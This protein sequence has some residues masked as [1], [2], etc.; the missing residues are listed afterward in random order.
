MVEAT[1]RW[2]ATVGESS[3]PGKGP[4]EWQVSV[5]S[6]P[7]DAPLSDAVLGRFADAVTR[8]VPDARSTCSFRDDRL[9]LTL[10]VRAPKVEQAADRAAH[11]FGRALTA[12]L[13]PRYRPSGNA[14]WRVR[15]A[16][17]EAMPAS[18]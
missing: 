18:S 11:A 2:G 14:Q 17:V 8:L 3:E 5:E 4:P 6:E 1:V 13:W 12:A 7:L 15:V 10:T 9:G 16:R